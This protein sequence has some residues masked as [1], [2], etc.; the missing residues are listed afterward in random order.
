MPQLSG[1]KRLG[2]RTTLADF[3]G[4]VFAKSLSRCHKILCLFSSLFDNWRL[5]SSHT[6][7]EN[8]FDQLPE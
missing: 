2:N 8:G 4:E 7:S 3:C 1:E 5:I 6:K